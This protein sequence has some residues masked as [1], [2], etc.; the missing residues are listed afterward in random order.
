MKDQPYPITH[1]L[2][3]ADL[4]APLD[5]VQ[6]AVLQRYIEARL[7]EW[8]T[9]SLT[10]VQDA[11]L[12]FAEHYYGDIIQLEQEWEILFYALIQANRQ[13]ADE[14]VIRLV[15]CLALVLPR[16]NDFRVA[17]QIL[18][19]GIQASK[20]LDSLKDYVYFLTLLGN[21]SFRRGFHQEGRVYWY[22]AVRLGRSANLPQLL[23]EPFV[24]FSHTIDIIETP[25]N[26]EQFLKIYPV[27]DAQGAVLAKFIHSFYRR[28]AHDLD[29]AYAEDQQCLKALAS[30]GVA[31]PL[32][33]NSLFRVVVQTEV[34]RA[35]KND[36][37]AEKLSDMAALLAMASSDTNTL[38]AI[39][40]DQARYALD[41][42]DI[43]QAKKV[44]NRLDELTPQLEFP[45]LD[46]YLEAHLQSKG[47]LDLIDPPHFSA[48]QRNSLLSKREKEIMRLVAAGY[49]NLAIAE[50]LCLSLKT[51]K[52]HLENIYS[53]L[54]V[55]N[56]T[57]AL[58]RLS[59]GIS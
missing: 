14:V 57:A 5:A 22:K 34:A 21:V 9:Q 24:N 4:H 31:A 46:P 19:L 58:A 55:H 43:K 28:A 48:E 27:Q 50:E 33:G 18:L 49:A 17:Q 47:L 36:I 51:V 52:K 10:H 32:S 44:L 1:P 20:A 13:G 53:K 3:P 16:L 59:H 42:D 56:R 38:R 11:A 45:Y 54:H 15:R 39:L 12:S 26:A 23:C 8:A 2:L 7:P 40:I 30:L 37:R 6:S 35:E 29:F 41:V 25:E